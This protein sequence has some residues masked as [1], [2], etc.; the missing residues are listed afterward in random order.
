MSLPTPNYVLTKEHSFG[1]DGN[2]LLA[3]TFVRP[4][5][6]CYVPSHIIE[7]PDNKWFNSDTEEYYYTRVGIIKIPKDYVRKV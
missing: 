3:G 7:H 4:I 5:A 6:L 2:K 1:R